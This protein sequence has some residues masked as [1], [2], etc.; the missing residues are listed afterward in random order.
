MRSLNN[1][2]V[3]SNLSLRLVTTVSMSV[4]EACNVKAVEQY[5]HQWSNTSM[6]VRSTGSS[7]R[8]DRCIRC[9]LLSPTVTIGQVRMLSIYFCPKQHL[10]LLSIISM[11]NQHYAD[12]CTCIALIADAVLATAPRMFAMTTVSAVMVSELHVTSGGL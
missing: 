10:P 1:A 7:D 11:S 8:R 5:K 12:D 3:L 4:S 9:F 2:P 6:N